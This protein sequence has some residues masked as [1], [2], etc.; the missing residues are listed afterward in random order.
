MFFSSCNCHL[1]LFFINLKFD[2]YYYY[3][4][5]WFFFI[6]E[7]KLNNICIRHVYLNLKFDCYYFLLWENLIFFIFE[8]Y[9]NNNCIRYVQ[10]CKTWID[11]HV[12]FFFLFFFHFFSFVFH[13]K[14]LQNY[15]HI[16]TNVKC[17]FCFPIFTHIENNYT[18]FIR[19]F[20]IFINIH[21]NT[22][23]Y[24][25]LANLDWPSITSTNIL[26]V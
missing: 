12:L 9:L 3:Y 2:Y 5:F 20:H 23:I 17:N 10:I 1:D 11:I 13:T 4:L 26:Y 15:F 7:I 25:K 8:I 6:F 16:C 22:Q 14:L 19:N 21:K 24:S 18:K